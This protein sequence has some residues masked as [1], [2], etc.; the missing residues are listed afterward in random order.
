M[1]KKSSI[2]ILAVLL[3]TMLFSACTGSLPFLG[4]N[5]GTNSGNAATLPQ[6]TKTVIGILKLEGTPQAVTAEQAKNLVNLYKAVKTMSTNTSSSPAEI[7]ALYAQIDENLTPDQTQAIS[8]MDITGQNMRTIM[9]DLGIQF[10][11][12]GGNGTRTANG[13]GGGF[14]GGGFPGGG[15]G[16][17]GGFGGGTGTTRPTSVA[18]ASGTRQQQQI[19]PGLL[20]AVIDL[21]NKRAGISTVTPTP[22]SASQTAAT[23][24]PGK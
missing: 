15:P 10:G 22:G 23:P 16:G 20:T 21:L 17:P 24:T 2:L 3:T 9:S 6:S 12:T 14:G 7:Q 19:N 13:N 4:Q 8:K 1:L 5:Q 11:G 18:G